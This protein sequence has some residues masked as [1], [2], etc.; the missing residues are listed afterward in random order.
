MLSKLTEPPAHGQPRL[1]SKLCQQTNKINN[2]THNNNNIMQFGDSMDTSHSY[3]DSRKLPWPSLKC[4]Q[5]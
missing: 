5:I 4:F 3:F 1:Q 2:N